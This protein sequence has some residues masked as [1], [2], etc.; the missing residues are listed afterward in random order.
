[1]M[2]G[3]ES[4]LGL[5]ESSGI[6]KGIA[7]SSHRKF[8]TRALGIFDLEPRFDFVLTS[9]SVTNGKPHP[10]VYQ[11]AARNHG[12]ET[13]QMLVLE[14]SVHGSSAG[15]ASGAITVAVPS[16]RVDVTQFG[17]VY[18]ICERLD[19]SAIIELIRN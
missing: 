6:P 15:V 5:L 3:L 10:E 14:D 12:I 18:A 16:R 13:G 1:M 4:L 2:P 7:T 8:A 17:E 9:E 11:T 19:D